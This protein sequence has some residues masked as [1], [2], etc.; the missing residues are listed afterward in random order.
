VEFFLTPTQETG[1]GDGRRTT[2]LLAKPLSSVRGHP[3]TYTLFFPL[4]H[5]H[6]QLGLMLCVSNLATRFRMRP[7]PRSHVTM[8]VPLVPFSC[9]PL[10]PLDPRSPRT[11]TKYGHTHTDPWYVH[12]SEFAYIIKLMKVV[13]SSRTSPN[14]PVARARVSTP[15]RSNGSRSVS[16]N[17]AMATFTLFSKFNIFSSFRPGWSD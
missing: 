16:N 9:R 10:S 3:S 12:L 1:T 17:F 7:P 8:T 6:L 13:Y 5:L 2:L 11:G 4:L 14:A 15:T